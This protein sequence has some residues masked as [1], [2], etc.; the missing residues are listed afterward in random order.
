MARL[1]KD[2]ID[3]YLQKGIDS[4]NRRLMLLGEI[5]IETA[6]N[7][8]KGLKLLEAAS[9][10]PVEVMISSEGGDV[11]D[12]FGIYDVLRASKCRIRTIGFGKIM[13]AAI[14]LQAAGDERYCYKNTHFMTHQAAWENPT[15]DFGSQHL[16]IVKHVMNMDIH[17]IKCLAAHTKLS[18][19]KWKKISQNLDYYFDAKKALEFGVVDQIID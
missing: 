19:A 8:V 2:W 9:S 1:A 7:F 14:L 10:D 11:Y 15:M 12:M 6:G 13:S 17:C 3:P 4:T 16:N 5:N 18:I